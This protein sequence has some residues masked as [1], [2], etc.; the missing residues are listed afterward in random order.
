MEIQK[1]ELDMA[2]EL[3]VTHRIFVSAHPV[4]IDSDLKYRFRILEPEYDNNLHGGWTMPVDIESNYTF[5][6]YIDAIRAGVGLTLNAA[7]TTSSG[8]LTLI[9]TSI[10]H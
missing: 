3:A 6:S 9:G 8:L 5:D 4:I 10:C 7:R 2:I 1:I